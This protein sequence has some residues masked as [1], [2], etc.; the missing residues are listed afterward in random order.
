M[1]VCLPSLNEF[2]NCFQNVQNYQ[3]MEVI[4]IKITQ[5]L[6]FLFEKGNN[7]LKLIYKSLL[8]ISFGT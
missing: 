7:S 6:K 8:K 1:H 4:W 2:K 3:N 5:T